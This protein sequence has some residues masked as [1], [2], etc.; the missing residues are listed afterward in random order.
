MVVFGKHRTIKI[1][2]LLNVYYRKSPNIS[3]TLVGDKLVDH[4][5]VIGADPTKYSLSTQR[6]AS[7]VNLRFLLKG[8]SLVNLVYI[9][10]PEQIAVGIEI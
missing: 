6:L 1:D 9:Y 10:A 3:R 8:F 5:D 7:V 2:A 4:S